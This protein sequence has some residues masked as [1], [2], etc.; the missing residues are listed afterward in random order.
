MNTTPAAASQRKFWLDA[1]RGLAILF[2]IYGHQQKSAPFYF[3][4]TSPVKVTM[5]FVISGYLF[6]Y[7]SGNIRAFFKNLLLK[8]VLPWLI[9]A[10]P[11]NLARE[12]VKG[13][14]A[15]YP[16]MLYRILSGEDFWYM[17]C[18]ILAE[19]IFFF[20]L[21]YARTPKYI[22][23]TS[24]VL[25]AAG[26]IAAKLNILGFAGLNTALICQIFLLFGQ[27]YRWYENRVQTH[28]Q[29]K[30]GVKLAGITAVYIIMVMANRF[31]FSKS[32]MNVHSNQYGLIPLA[33]LSIWVGCWLLF[34]ITKR[35][36]LPR[37]LCFI[38]QNTLFFYMYEQMFRSVFRHGFEILHLN[39]NGHLNSILICIPACAALCVAALVIN[40]V[41]PFAVGKRRK[42]SGRI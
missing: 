13:A 28:L 25:G 40:R 26:F 30:T 21:K 22:C 7:R 9:L 5:F 11:Q 17:P 1:C 37:I 6:N 3:M 12:V 42:V 35:I 38:G 23:I 2:V 14:S 27:M 8:I 32:N 15:N 20:V 29:N 19:S 41:F 34:E 4:F 31:L 36:R 39:F 24:A 16:G 18:C 33:L 10:I